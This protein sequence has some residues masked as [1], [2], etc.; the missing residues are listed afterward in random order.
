MNDLTNLINDCYCPFKAILF[1]RDATDSFYLESYDMDSNGMAINAHPLSIKESGEIAD[2]LGNS[3]ELKSHFVNEATLL[4]P[5]VLY[6]NNDRKGSVVWHTTSKKVNLFFHRILEIP[7]G[8][9]HVP[10]MLWKADK[11]SL[12][13][14]AMKDNKRPTDETPLY[15][16]PFFNV[17]DRGNVCMGNVRKHIPNGCTLGDFISLWEKYFFNS[18]FSHTIRGGAVSGGELDAFWKKQ[19]SIGSKFPVQRLKKCGI[20]VREVLC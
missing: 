3:R 19:M 2:A 4:P 13:V 7:D 10:A 14:W 5:N 15:H 18:T 8:F 9:A 16:A 20:K 6:V 12:S 11:D 17:Y 1:Y